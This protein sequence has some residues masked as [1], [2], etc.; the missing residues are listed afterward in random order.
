MLSCTNILC[1]AI[2]LQALI[3][4]NY[5]PEEQFCK[6]YVYIGLYAVAPRVLSCFPQFT[7]RISPLVLDT[8]RNGKTIWGGRECRFSIPKH[9]YLDIDATS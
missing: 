7:I 8:R 2:E 9:P 6:R 1:L 3:E 5:G 4:P